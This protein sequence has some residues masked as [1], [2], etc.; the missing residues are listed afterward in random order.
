[1]KQEQRKSWLRL[2]EVSFCGLFLR[3]QSRGGDDQS[4][5]IC[6]WSPLIYIYVFL[7]S[8]DSALSTPNEIVL[9]GEEFT[10]ISSS[11]PTRAHKKVLL[12]KSALIWT[13]V[14]LERFW[15]RAESA[16]W[17][18]TFQETGEDFC[19]YLL[20]IDFFR[21][22]N[23]SPRNMPDVCWGSVSSPPAKSLTLSRRN[24]GAFHATGCR[25][26]WLSEAFQL[27]GVEGD[28]KSGFSCL[29]NAAAAE[30]EI[31]HPMMEEPERWHGQLR[32]TN[33]TT[34]VITW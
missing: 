20:K 2:D 9:W 3:R 5:T 28:A 7:K 24:D 29:T 31:K 4:C 17:N 30:R 14:N 11:S 18:C 21:L 32:Q 6:Q 26:R 16:R 19:H 25:V 23:N 15:Q 1:M 13:D 8:S 12:L 10:T 22:V 33:T 34:L 27:R